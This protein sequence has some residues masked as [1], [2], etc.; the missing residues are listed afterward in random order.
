MTTKKPRAIDSV[1][2]YQAVSFEKKNETFFST[3]SIANKPACTI[4]LCTDIDAVEVISAKDHILI[5]LTNISCIYLK[6]PTKIQ[7]EKKASKE[8]K[9]LKEIATSQRD[10]VSRPK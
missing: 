9:K 8:V 7:D 1:R 5:P 6:S 4:S 10:T 2:I 3:R